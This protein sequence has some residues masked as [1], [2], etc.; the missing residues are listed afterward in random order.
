MG[1]GC[2]PTASTSV[3][4]QH[5]PTKHPTRKPLPQPHPRHLILRDRRENRLDLPEAGLGP[6]GASSRESTEPRGPSRHD[7]TALTHPQVAPPS[8]SIPNCTSKAHSAGEELSVFLP[9]PAPLG[10]PCDCSQFFPSSRVSHSG[11]VLQHVAASARSSLPRG[12]GGDDAMR[13][14]RVSVARAFG[15]ALFLGCFFVGRMRGKRGG[16]G[17]RGGGN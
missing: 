2:W 4:S 1:D 10:V 9:L 15:A 13:F 11:G 14:P 5:S 16:K 17:G 3:P 12:G 8:P 6:G 7:A